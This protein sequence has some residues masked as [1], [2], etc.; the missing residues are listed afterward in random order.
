MA[1]VQFPQRDWKAPVAHGVMFHHFHGRRFPRVQGSISCQDLEAILQ[2]IGL[3]R[4]LSPTEWLEKLETDRL[5]EW[6]RCLTF[7]DGLLC[8]FE[9]VLPLLERYRL[10]AFW[11][12]YSSVFEGQINLGKLE[13]YRAF[14]CRFFATIDDFYTSF[15]Q[16]VFGAGF[17]KKTSEV[18][19][20]ARIQQMTSVFPFYSVNDAK[21]RL[22]RDLV[23]GRQEYE[24]IMDEIIQEHGI[25]MDELSKDLWMSDAQLRYLTGQGHMVGLHSYSHPTTLAEL[26]YTQQRE[27]Y[28]KNYQHILAVCGGA[29][30]AM[31]HPANSYGK[32][33]IEIL[34]ELGILCGFRS[35]ML[36][37]HPGGQ[38]NPSRYEMARE[39][40]ANVLKVLR[41]SR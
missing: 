8:Q 4:I 33:T 37:P 27:E 29:P 39:D 32:E 25:D 3:R 22:V 17:A 31:A 16:R 41:G 7:D 40:D 15:F 28:Q 38:T 10:K 9:V 20:E 21:F 2:C 1:L 35:N 30:M 26:S 24:A 19:T 6:D 34:R 13:I 14:R 36:P 5:D 18:A 23:L 12:V 11:F